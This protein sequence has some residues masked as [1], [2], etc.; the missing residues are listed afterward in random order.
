MY[1]IIDKTHTSHLTKTLFYAFP[2]HPA[3]TLI[4]YFADFHVINK[5]LLFPGTVFSHCFT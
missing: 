3:V 4:T 5:S 2:I 1:L